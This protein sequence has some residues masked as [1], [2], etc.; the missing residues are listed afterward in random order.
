MSVSLAIREMQI[1]TMKYHFTPA[2]MARFKKT[3][4][5][6]VNENTQRAREQ[7]RGK[8]KGPSLEKLQI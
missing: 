6:T 4:N 1:K 3:E 5:S 8:G 2:R 7:R